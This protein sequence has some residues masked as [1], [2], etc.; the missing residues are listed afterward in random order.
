[1]RKAELCGLQWKDL[2]LDQ[3][4]I[5]I[6][7]QLVKIG[8]EP[9]FGPPKNGK[10]RTVDLD[11]RTIDLLRKHKAAQAAHRLLLGTAY[12]DHGLIFMREFGQPLLMNNLGQREY[13]RLIKAAGVKTITFHGLRHTCATLAL[14]AGVPVKVVSERLGHKRIEMTLNIYAHALPS[15]QQEAAAKLGKLLHG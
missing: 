3:R 13:A 12:R 11:E 1:M 15:M 7:R 4:R 9:V 14:K 2:D 8:P 5:S 10:A 6:V